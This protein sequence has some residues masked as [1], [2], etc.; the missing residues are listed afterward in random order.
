VWERRDNTTRL[1]HANAVAF[2]TVEGER[3][4]ALLE[5]TRLN[6]ELDGMRRQVIR[7]EAQVQALGGT[8]A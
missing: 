5:V 1:D 3:D 7:L 4:R 6:T 8:I 2:K